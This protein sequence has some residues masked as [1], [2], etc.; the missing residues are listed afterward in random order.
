MHV[1]E[2]HGD[3]TES[4]VQGHQDDGET[5]APSYE[6]AERARTVQPGEERLRRISAMSVNA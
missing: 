4:P 3:A 6:Q 5:G 2:R 1:P